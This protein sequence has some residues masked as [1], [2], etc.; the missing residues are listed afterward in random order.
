APIALYPA[1]VYARHFLREYAQYL[2]LEVDPLVEAFDRQHELQ[3][4]PAEPALLPMEP[5]P[6]RWPVVALTLLSIAA[7][8]TIFV[9]GQRPREVDAPEPPPAALPTT[10]PTAGAVAPPPSTLPPPPD[11]VE[12]IRAV[13]RVDGD[14]WIRA[15]A[16]GEVV[17]TETVSSG[18]L[19]FR[20]DEELLLE[21]GSAGAV[22]LEVNG[23]P[24]E[25]GAPGTVERFRF[26]WL[27][28]A[29]VTTEG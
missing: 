11:E 28:G 7:A 19:V 27:D 18:R 25:T 10:S 5:R 4:E 9:T 26:E 14:C 6:R 2:N 29:L 3:V 24:V 23:D 8:A 12:G 1:P 20:A 22:R 13:L 21:L 17:H 16:D 15:T